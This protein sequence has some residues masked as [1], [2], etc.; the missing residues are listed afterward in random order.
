MQFHILMKQHSL[1]LRHFFFLFAFILFSAKALASSCQSHFFVVSKNELSLSRL[2]KEEVIKYHTTWKNAK[3]V[4]V[5]NSLNYGRKGDFEKA[6]EQVSGSLKELTNLVQAVIEATADNPTLVIG[7]GGSPSPVLA[8]LSEILPQQKVLEL[9]LSIAALPQNLRTDKP[10]ALTRR[11]NQD[12]LN[13]VMVAWQKFL[14][15]ASKLQGQKILLVDFASSGESLLY[16]A[17]VLKLFY[18]AQGYEVE[19]ETFAFHEKGRGRSQDFEEDAENEKP[20][21]HSYS[22]STGLKGWSYQMPYSLARHFIN[23]DFKILA[24]YPSYTPLVT[25]LESLRP[26]PEYNEF[27]SL[28]K[29]LLRN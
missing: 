8:I 17:Q 9:P 7:L 2:T 10:Q 6:M 5:E 22:S 27:R 16:S 14:P 29:N 4:G 18:Q 1:N 12:Q 23:Q 21:I 25:P 13:E 24:Q 3:G 26:R 15:S 11:L 28:L 19:I 20:L